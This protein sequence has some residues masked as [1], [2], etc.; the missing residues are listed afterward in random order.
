MTSNRILLTTICRPYGV[1]TPEAEA[2]GMQMELFNNQI[3]RGQGVHSPRANYWTFPLYF[4]AENIRVPATV[5]D[6]PSWR[7]FTRELKRGYTHVGISFIQTNVLKARRMAEYIRAHHPDLRII[8]GGYGTALP[9]LRQLVPCD[10]VCEGEGIAWLRRYF[11]EPDDAPI[12]HPILHGVVKKHLYGFPSVDDDSAVI[13]PG[14]GCPNACFF[15]STSSKFGGQYLPILK[16]GRDVFAI[17]RQ[18]EET[19]GVREF[20]VIDE[21]FLKESDRARDFLAELEKHRKTYN[22]FVFSSAEAILHFGIDFLVRLGVHGV[23]I[24]VE[25][26]VETFN[27]LKGIDP[28][29]LIAELQDHGITVISSSILFLEHHDRARLDADIDWAIGLGSDMHQFMQLTPLPGTP[30]F[31]DYLQRGKLIPRFPYSRMSGQNALNFVHDHFS[32]EEAAAITRQAFRRKY[33]TDG[34][35]TV[36]MAHTIAR[37]YQRALADS[38]AR[39]QAGLGWNPESRRYDRPDPAGTDPYFDARLAMFRRRMEEF[40]PVFLA[41]WVFAP[42]GHSRR[43]CRSVQRLFH[44]LIGPDRLIDHLKS[45]I[46]LGSA[47]VEYGRIRWQQALGREELVRQPHSRRIEYRSENR[48]CPR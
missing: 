17:C 8:L 34:P 12:R 44:R 1:V 22:F 41:A 9:D 2:L 39:R 10:D 13:F 6:F 19:L 33:E 25:T 26:Q 48:P 28:A 20:A 27:K 15:C 23:W 40:R 30:L 21:N 35:A 3:T 47:L 46:L 16:T 36:N 37:G 43:K 5:L 14:L 42:N 4:L 45:L 24:G 7:D 11:G 32:S 31:A 18:A 38:A 29:R